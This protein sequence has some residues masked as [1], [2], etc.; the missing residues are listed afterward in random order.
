M[1]S[2][3]IPSWGVLEKD[4]KTVL[5][6]MYFCGEKDGVRSSSS[7]SSAFCVVTISHVWWATLSLHRY[8]C[9]NG[10]ESHRILANNLLMMICSLFTTFVCFRSL[11]SRKARPLMMDDQ[12]DWE[13][14]S[15]QKQSWFQSSIRWLLMAEKPDRNRLRWIQ[16]RHLLRQVNQL[17][18]FMTQKY[19][20]NMT[21]FWLTRTQLTNYI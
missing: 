7:A 20:W 11:L 21:I 18:I 1:H 5:I 17:H 6:T 19:I 13:F 9:L 2:D 3:Q 15:R 16:Q 4:R 8:H 12:L 10:A 14:L